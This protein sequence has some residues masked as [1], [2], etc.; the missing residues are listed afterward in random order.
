MT[1]EDVCAAIVEQRK[2]TLENDN[3]K[4]SA[5]TLR[6]NRSR[7]RKRDRRLRELEKSIGEHAVGAERPQKRP[8][9]YEQQRLEQHL[10]TIHDHDKTR[11]RIKN[12]SVKRSRFSN[13]CETEYVSTCDSPYSD[14]FERL[15]TN[16]W[17]Q[18]VE[19]SKRQRLDSKVGNENDVYVNPNLAISSNVVTQS[20]ENS[21]PVIV[22]QMCMIQDLK[23]DDDEESSNRTVS[24]PVEWTRMENINVGASLR[25]RRRPPWRLQLID[26][27]LRF[28]LAITPVLEP[29]VQP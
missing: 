13:V 25:D 23:N 2:M 18:S 24:P 15:V 27:D 4:T 7:A 14:E 11:A 8:T 6:S 21:E 29:I 28:R 3:K 12:I 16:S 19:N 9:P 5:K 20:T 22:G 1:T 10:V 17:A 26:E